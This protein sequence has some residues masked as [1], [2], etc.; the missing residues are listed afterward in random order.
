MQGDKPSRDIDSMPGPLS[1]ALWS[2]DFVMQAIEILPVSLRGGRLWS[3]RP[4]HAD[5]FVVAWPAS[6]KPEEV[7]EQA[8]VQL[9]ME[10]A[11][12]HS[13]SWRHANQEVV[14]TYI[15][16]VSPGAVPPPSWQIVEV[17]RSE[18]ARGD[19]T[20][21]PTSIGVMQVQEHALRHLAWLRQDDPTISTLLDDWS[22]ALSDY[23]PEPFRAL[24]GP[25]M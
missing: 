9:G 23:I 3:L 16:V 25:A 8:M 12:L 1:E 21:P 6:A 19:A 13:T 14:L 24:G 18:L 2:P 15:A 10:P 20:A 5:S 22:D 17:A 7:A 4:E 11:V